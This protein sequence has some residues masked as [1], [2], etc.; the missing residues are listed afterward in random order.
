MF[1][2]CLQATAI[3]VTLFVALVQRT[4]A[5]TAADIVINDTQVFPESLTSARDGT[6]F[7]GSIGKNAVYRATP[8]A[9]RAD[10][11]ILPAA[12]EL[13]AVLGVLADDGANT[14]WVCSSVFGGRGAAA[15]TPPASGGTA[16]KSFDLRTGALKG[17]FPFPG[18]GLCNDIAV[19]Q[20]GTAYATD[21]Q[22]GRVLRLKKG[23]S[24]FDVWSA[25]PLLASA[26]GIAIL[27]DGA[28]YVNTFMTGTLVR[29]AV[30]KEGS[31]GAPM[32]L[33][34]SRPIVRPDGMRSVGGNTM[35]LVEGE[36]R[37]D[38][39]TVDGNR[40]QVRVL[41]EGFTGPTAVT[42]VGDIAYVIEAKLNYRNDPNL[43]GQDPGP[44]RALPVS[45]RKGR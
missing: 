23:A 21:T 8:K 1:K 29:I 44:F 35:L 19:A 12:G 20:D 9:T 39:V 36:G 3:G 28:V 15:A 34:T 4:P 41:K 26:D 2:R 30:S 33:E 43:R 27:G 22:G 6:V 13:Q 11:W 16:L 24:A 17:S 40:A 38:E 10:A 25:D 7:I 45:Y 32:K 37:L 18:G 42:L 5:Q 14:L 31:A